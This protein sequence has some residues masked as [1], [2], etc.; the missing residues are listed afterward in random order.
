MDSFMVD[1][2]VKEKEGVVVCIISD[3][4]FNAIALTDEYTDMFFMPWCQAPLEFRL[5]EQYK[6]IAK[7]VAGDTFD[8]EYGK[9][10][11]YRKAYLKYATALEKKVK[12]IQSSHKEYADQLQEKLKIAVRKIDGK[13]EAA[14]TL[15]DKVLKEQ[16]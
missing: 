8:E 2:I 10:I 12:F 16:N 5:N 1:Y 13:T 7:C 4:E 6:G 9:R 11:A 3:C 14:Q 15:L